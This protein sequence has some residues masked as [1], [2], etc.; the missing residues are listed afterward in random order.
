MPDPM[1]AFREKFR[2][3]CVADRERILRLFDAWKRAE[4]GAQDDLLS[5]VHGLAGAG[6][7][8]G[9]ASLSERAAEVEARLLERGAESEIDYNAL[10]AGLLQELTMIEKN[11][12]PRK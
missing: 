4:T 7:T 6:G 2:Q 9:F 11:E 5:I 12:T 1:I 8:F 10:I 3:R